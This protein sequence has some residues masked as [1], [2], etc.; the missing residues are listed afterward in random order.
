MAYNCLNTVLQYNEPNVKEY[1]NHLEENNGNCD[2][3]G[4]NVYL[5]ITNINLHND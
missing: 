2:R 4:L 1:V 3:S 5:N